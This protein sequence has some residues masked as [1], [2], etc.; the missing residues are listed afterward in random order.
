M[1]KYSDAGRGNRETEAGKRKTDVHL[2]KGWHGKSL[3]HLT[4]P[5]RC[6]HGCCILHYVWAVNY[7]LITHFINSLFLSIP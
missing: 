5:G 7:S 1:E 4:E 3:K 2:V 6:G